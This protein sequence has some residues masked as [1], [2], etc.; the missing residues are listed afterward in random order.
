M[1]SDNDLSA[2][3]ADARRRLA[4]LEAVDAEQRRAEK[5]QSALYRI[6]ELASAAED[7]QDFY[8]AV[9]AVVG[10]LMY[11]K[12]FFIAL[13]DE[14]RQLINWPYWEDEVDVDWPAANTWVD[15]GSRESR[16]TTAYVLRTG[17]PQWLPRKR[18][19][20]LI[21]KGEFELWG[22]LSEDWLGV[23]LTSE[24]RTVGALVVQSYTK[25][26]TYTEQDKELLAYVGQHVGAALSR[27][28]A[29]E[30]TRQ[31]N[32]ELATVNS[33]AQ[34]L[35]SQLDLDAL[36]EL[37]GERVRETFDADIVYVA[38]QDEAAGRVD[39][40]Y[41]SEAGERRH[42]PSLEYGQGLTSQILDSGEPLVLN[43]SEQYDE[44]AKQRVGTP[45]RS[46][47]GVPIV[48]G[49][50]AIGVISVQSTRE[51]GRFGE[52]DSGLLATIAANVGVAIQN[53][54]LFDAQR[55]AEQQYRGL[56]E[57][58]PLA[59]YTD[60]PDPSGATGG[61]PVYMSP[62]VEQM[63]G[64]PAERWLEETFFASIIHPED[65]DRV[66]H[67]AT[68]AHLDSGDD[69]NDRWSLDYRLV[70]ADGR[71]VWVRDDAWLVRDASGEITHLQGYFMDMTDHMESAAELDRQKQYFE[72]LVEISPVAIVVMD[73]DE[74]VTGWNPAA[75]EIV[76]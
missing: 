14:Q 20:E 43:R 73:A 19:E 69:T 39:F 56:V 74:Q 1:R 72:S 45:S 34:A 26:F 53:A 48:V 2:E 13:F 25:E 76:G 36:I 35:A 46:Y 50:T 32:A 51:A 8:R 6:A 67:A 71:E 62:R 70:A 41:Y 44:L 3:L 59:V 30:E 24:G 18:Q 52:A 22:E 31:R 28:R 15:F 47:L 33:V 9:H 66:L 64:Y 21:A 4:E 38:L 68:L 12:N 16:G 60:K 7:M 37:V 11:A 55:A 17:E 57:E 5:V 27:A 61:I 10:E 75:A 65:R 54:R 58:L 29:I 63:F 40:A 23:P 42:E 49:D